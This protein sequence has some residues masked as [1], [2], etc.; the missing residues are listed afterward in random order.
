MKLN[1]KQKDLILSWGYNKEDIPQIEDAIRRS[2]YTVDDKTTT[3]TEA[4]KILGEEDFLSGISRSAFHFTSC[5]ESAAGT[6][7]YF[8]SS[9][10]FR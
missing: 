1:K 3:S 2:T 8:N 7:V 4:I 5:R 6:S 9:V 10:I